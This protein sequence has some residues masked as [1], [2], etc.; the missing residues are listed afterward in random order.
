MSM[1]STGQVIAAGEAGGPIHVSRDGGAT[2]TTGDSANA[3]WISSA[4]TASGDRIYAVQYG[5]D[6]VM[7]TNGGA[8]WQAVTSSPLVHAA[9]GLGFEAVTVS[10][11]GQRIAVAVQDGPIVLSADSGAT[12]HAATLPDGQPNHWWRWIDGSADGRVLVAVSHNAEVYRSTDA[13]ATWSRL[14]IAVGGAAAN[15]SWYRVKTSADGSAIA[16]VANTFGGAPGTGIYVSRDGGATWTKPFALVT[17]YTFLAMSA[18]G[19]RIAASMS[20]TGSAAGRV[21]LSIDG[22][23]SFSVLATPGSDT[24]W[25]ALAMS[26]GGGELAAATGAFNTSSTG[27]LYTAH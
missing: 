6:L 13:G 9:G 23:A 27:L 11:D 3:V 12:W 24:N 25:R 18:D 20:N 7:S 19:Q 4:M 5:G 22:G 21:V 2:W 14:T 8:S 16:L 1:S 26:A 17:D 10:Q 15:E